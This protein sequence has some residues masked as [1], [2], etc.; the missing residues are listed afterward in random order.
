[1]ANLGEELAILADNPTRKMTHSREPRRCAQ[2]RTGRKNRT[3]ALR[4]TR[5][6]E[7]R[8][9]QNMRLQELH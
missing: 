8:L 2:G 9:C 3:Q 6:A 4:G 1:V 5:N 7:Q